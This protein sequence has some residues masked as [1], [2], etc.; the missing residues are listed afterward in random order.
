LPD[1]V[2]ALE[3]LVGEGVKVVMFGEFLGKVSQFNE[4]G[5]EVDQVLV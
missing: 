1:V 2:G 5:F 4:E 3:Y